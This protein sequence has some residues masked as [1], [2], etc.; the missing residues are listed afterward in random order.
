MANRLPQSDAMFCWFDDN[1]AAI[2]FY[3][4]P[5]CCYVNIPD[6]SLEKRRYN[7]DCNECDAYTA[8]QKSDL[9]TFAH[10]LAKY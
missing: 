1:E 8:S 9:Y 10:N 6:N 5:H 3:G 2:E 7:Q 4:V